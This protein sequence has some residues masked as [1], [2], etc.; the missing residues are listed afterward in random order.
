MIWFSLK[1]SFI[2]NTK[3]LLKIKLFEIYSQPFQ[4]Q[5]WLIL[6]KN[7]NKYWHAVSPSV[8]RTYLHFQS[9]FIWVCNINKY[10]LMLSPANAN[11]K[12]I[13][14]PTQLTF[15][16]G[17]FSESRLWNCLIGGLFSNIVVTLTVGIDK[18]RIGLNRNIY[19][20]L[21]FSNLMH[22]P[23]K[24]ICPQIFHSLYDA[25]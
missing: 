1:F 16:V 10:L 15:D 11:L 7:V 8:V 13:L 21:Q 25:V 20:R 5:Y 17:V 6:H 19:Q 18:I 22:D 24:K 14:L 4:A 9:I 2:V 12:E 23:R 3:I